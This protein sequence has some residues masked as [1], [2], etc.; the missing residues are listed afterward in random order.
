MKILRALRLAP[1][2]AAIVLLQA[3]CG[4][5]AGLTAVDQRGSP[6]A[7]V[8]AG[9]YYLFRST[10]LDHFYGRLAAAPVEHPSSE[11]AMT[12][13]ACARVAFNGQVGVCLESGSGLF[14][15]T[16]AVFF[17]RSFE[18]LGSVALQGYPNRAQESAD[19]RYAAVTT[20]VNGSSYAAAGFS[21]ITDI[22]DVAGRHVE[23]ELDDL[24]VTWKGKLFSTAGLNFW[25]V[26]FAD[27]D[28]S[29]F[30]TLGS[31]TTTY[32]I[33]GS[34]RTRTA[35]VLRP[36]V[37]CPSLS[38]D[39]TQLAF[40]KRLPGPAVRWQLSVLD[41][42]TLRDYPLAETRSVDDQAYWLNDSTV[43]YGLEQ[44]PGGSTANGISA[45]TAGG[46]IPTQM[47]AV[48]ADGSGRPRLLLSG[49]WSAVLVP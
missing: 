13:L 31:A 24:H 37:E 40:K 27:N 35:I 5:P 12:G 26:T 36:G 19:G 1:S 46:S 32:L 34:I 43:V 49:A 47:W 7:S 3:A 21:T 10:T 6:L 15:T 45:L 28:E 4:S 44:A 18:P 8:T 30:A 17:G 11:R 2:L 41:L 22:L 9:P 48:P 16:R 25:G 14:G 20:F 33:E 42:A 29:F 38:P 39:G 23:L